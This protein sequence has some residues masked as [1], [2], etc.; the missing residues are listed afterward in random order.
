MDSL[1]GCAVRRVFLGFYVLGLVQAAVIFS[2]V[3][4]A[5][6]PFGDRSELIARGFKDFVWAKP[7]PSETDLPDLSRLRHQLPWPVRFVSPQA[8]LGNVMATFQPFRTPPYW[9]GGLDMLVQHGEKIYSPVAGRLEGGHYSYTGEANGHKKKLWSPWP[10]SGDPTY[11]EIAVV[12]DDGLRFEFHHV[13]RAKL[14]TAIVDKLN[15]GGGRVSV[16]EWIGTAVFFM[17]GYHHVHYNVYLPDGTPAN[18]EFLTEL[19]PD[20]EAPIIGG[21]YAVD[22]SGVGRPVARGGSVR[23]GT[24][25]LVVLTRDHKTSNKYD[26]VPVRST[27]QFEGAAKP[28]WVWDFSQILR[29]SRGNL[30]DL[31]EFYKLSLDLGGRAKLRTEGGYG[32]GDS[33]IRFPLSQ[34]TQPGRFQLRLEDLAGNVTS[35]EGELTL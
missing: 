23:M 24:K 22:P 6:E 14:P 2:N 4:R 9:H 7:S 32:L 13:D 20:V 16:G 11:F 33:L 26:H 28:A 1:G 8:L 21:V 10:A 17:D 3:S 31:R 18:P 27:L 5:D 12:T 25:E 19:L 15:K 34:V 30:A 29:D 35:F